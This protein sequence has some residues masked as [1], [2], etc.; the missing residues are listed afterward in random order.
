MQTYFP[1]E[2]WRQIYDYDCTFHEIWKNVLR[3]LPK[4][5]EFQIGFTQHDTLRVCQYIQFKH[6]KCIIWSYQIYNNFDNLPLNSHIFLDT[7]FDDPQQQRIHIEKLLRFKNITVR[8][9]QY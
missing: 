5:H 4:V 8:R 9:R 6:K 1:T 3:Q 7:Q 2:I